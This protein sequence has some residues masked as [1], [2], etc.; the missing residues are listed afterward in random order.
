MQVR[1]TLFGIHRHVE[2][3]AGYFGEWLFEDLRLCRQDRSIAW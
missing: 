3:L 2:S 1:A